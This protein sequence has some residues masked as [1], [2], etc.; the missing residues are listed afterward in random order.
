[1]T[2]KSTLSRTTLALT[3][4]SLFL[5]AALSK[6]ESNVPHCD[7][8]SQACQSKF[9][10][11]RSISGSKGRK[12]EGETRRLNDGAME[13]ERGRGGKEENGRRG[14]AVMRRKRPLAGV[15]RTLASAQDFHSQI[16]T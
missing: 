4:F 1:M 12:R 15:E 9:R 16:F 5:T 13:E 6:A 10:L 2:H 7:A 11:T 3:V 14:E 8:K